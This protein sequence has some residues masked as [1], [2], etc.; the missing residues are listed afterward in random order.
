MKGDRKMT[1]RDA[2]RVLPD[3]EKIQIA[4]AGIVYNLDRNDPLMLD[5]YGDYLIDR[6][7]A[8][9]INEKIEY[10]LVVALRPVKA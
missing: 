9:E 7:Q 2:V 3:D 5:A 10:E 1:V 8:F 4:Y 6:L